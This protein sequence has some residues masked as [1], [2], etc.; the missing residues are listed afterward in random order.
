MTLSMTLR[1]LWV[2]ILSEN[3]FVR[4]AVLRVKGFIFYIQQTVSFLE[5]LILTHSYTVSKVNIHQQT[6]NNLRDLYFHRR[7]LLPNTMHLTCNNCH[8]YISTW[9]YSTYAIFIMLRVRT[10]EHKT[11][12]ML[13]LKKPL[14]DTMCF[15]SCKYLRGFPL[16]VMALGPLEE[17][18]N[19]Y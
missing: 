9:L 7:T 2:W 6:W 4:P 1:I 16:K 12:A 8:R 18:T 5:M 11:I 19:Y 13:I 15:P 3:I 10:M 17:K 14:H